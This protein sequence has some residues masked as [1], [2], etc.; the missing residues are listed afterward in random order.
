MVHNVL[1]NERDL[2]VLENNLE[3]KKPVINVSL[4]NR[5]ME[6]YKKAIAV[7]KFLIAVAFLVENYNYSF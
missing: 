4:I 5:N 6:L 1:R 2:G 7:R 3:M